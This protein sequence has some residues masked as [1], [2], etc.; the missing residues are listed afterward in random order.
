[1]KRLEHLGQTAQEAMGGL[2][3][4]HELKSR[5]Q[6]AARARKPGVKAPRR[7]PLAAVAASL[8]VLVAAG[9]LL[10]PGALVPGAMPGATNDVF[11]SLPAG[12]STAVP[13]VA[14]ALLDVPPGSITLAAGNANPEYRSVWA[15]ANGSSF[16]LVGVEG[17]FYRLMRN[18]SSVPQS[19][20]G[21]GL[22]Q[23][24]EFTD[25]PAL[26]DTNQVISNAVSQGETIY[27]VFGMDG[28]MVAARVAGEMRAFQ[29][30]S[31][32]NSAV[33]GRES[34]GDTLG[35][36]GK[37]VGLEL[38][39]VG[40]VTD[41]STAASLVNTLLSSASFRSASGSQSGS[42][43]LL[44]QL[45]NG[46]VVQMFAKNDTLSACGSWSAPEFFDAFREAVR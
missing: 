4:G 40:T 32:A 1:V 28:A 34:L 6:G 23:V 39:G 9:A 36:S 42:Q 33:L 26:A 5:I 30:V 38:S 17:R 21:Q 35:V 2:H 20:L 29:R 46:L 3:A 41:Q 18:P 27:A 14:R 43:A 24:T 44:I 31:F 13:F 22:G 11:D 45:S 12:Q 25:E 37:V 15:P 8:A 16:P 19:L 10:V 7:A